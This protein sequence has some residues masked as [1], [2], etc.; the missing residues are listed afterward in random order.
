MSL[1]SHGNR[2]NFYLWETVYNNYYRNTIISITT[3]ITVSTYTKCLVSLRVL[4]SQFDKESTKCHDFYHYILVVIVPS[5]ALLYEGRMTE[6]YYLSYPTNYKPITDDQHKNA[7]T[8]HG[9]YHPST[10]IR[11]FV[12]CI[13]IK[14]VSTRRNYNL[15]RDFF[16]RAWN[17][18]S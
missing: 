17:I 9:L 1:T 5:F 2:Y 12:M 11:W 16:V 18:E 7:Y 14:N 15:R 10:F 3:I 13:I 8:F 6:G 4:D